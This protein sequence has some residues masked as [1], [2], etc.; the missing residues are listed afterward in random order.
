MPT[1]HCPLDALANGMSKEGEHLHE[2]TAK[3]CCAHL[4]LL[5]EAKASCAKVLLQGTPGMSITAILAQPYQ[6][7]HGIM[8][9]YRR[10]QHMCF[11]NANLRAAARRFAWTAECPSE[12][13][14]KEGSPRAHLGRCWPCLMDLQ[15]QVTASKPRH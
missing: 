4:V 6:G 7:E 8:H 14:C 13:L 3:A 1:E 9:R 15:S 5:C 10:S 12:L 11:L 2:I